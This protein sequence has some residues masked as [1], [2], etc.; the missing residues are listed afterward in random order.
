MMPPFD[1]WVL[2]TF[3]DRKPYPFIQSPGTDAYATF[4]PDGR[5]VAYQSSELGQTEIY[6]VPFPGP[7]GRWQVS[8]GGGGQPFWPQGKELFYVSNDFQMIGVE[9]EVQGKNFLVGKSRRLFERQSIGGSLSMNPDAGASI[10]VNRDG[11]RWLV[12]APVD[13]RNASPLILT[14]NWISESRK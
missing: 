4:S 2:P 11:T 10:D 13:E 12:A 5:W 3:G 6:V 14:T 1:I 8:K 9:F 7:G